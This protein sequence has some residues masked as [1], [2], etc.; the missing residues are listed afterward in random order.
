MNPFDFKTVQHLDITAADAP[1]MDVKDGQIILMAERNGARIMITAPL[2][3]IMP[4]VAKTTVRKPARSVAVSTT[5]SKPRPSMQGANNSLSKLN[6][7]QVKEIRAI[8]ADR[9]QRRKYGTKVAMYRDLASRYGVHTLTV[10]N[11]IDRVS[12]KHI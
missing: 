6:E 9:D 11:I 3:G 7:A 10:K 1:S 8:A 5:T 4:R 12:W 2:N